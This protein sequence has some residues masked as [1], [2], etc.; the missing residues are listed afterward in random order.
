MQVYQL[1]SKEAPAWNLQAAHI[2]CAPR[3]CGKEGGGLGGI[4]SA[5]RRQTGRTSNPANHTVVLHASHNRPRNSL[6][7]PKGHASAP[8]LSIIW[9][10]V[11]SPSMQHNT[12]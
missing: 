8:S 4:Q 11:S 2:H 1:P 10:K 3:V 9:L 6:D 7:T 5:A 12:I